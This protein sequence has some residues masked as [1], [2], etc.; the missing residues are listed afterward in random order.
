MHPLPPGRRSH[1]GRVRHGRPRRRLMFIGEGPGAEEDRQG[2]PFVGRSGQLLD[3]LMLEELGITR[4]RCYIA[5]VVKCR[6]PD[7]RDP[8]AGRDRGLPPVPHAA[9]RPDPSRRRGD[10]RASSPRSGCSRRARASRSCG[11]RSTRSRTG[12]SSP[13]CTRPP[14]CGAVPSRWPRCGPTSCGPSWTWRRGRAMTGTPAPDHARDDEG[15]RDPG[16]RRRPG[17][18][19]PRRRPP[20][21][22]GRPGRRQDGV[23]PGLRPGARRER[24]RSPAPPSPS[25]TSTTAAC[26]LHHLDVYRLERLGRGGRPRPR[27]DARRRRRHARRV[28]RRHRLG[29]PGRLPGGAPRPSATAT[30]TATSSCGPAGQRW[31]GALG[32]RVA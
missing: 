27:R 18:A 30:T 2:L 7:N 3:R 32:G 8:Q 6:P 16:A 1:A 29:L 13:P 4:D 25:C 28:G 12:C 19:G 20:P 22:R 17:R 14:R 9:A 24:A 23:R 31:A 21:A 5:N 26:A 11:A 15:G 10:A